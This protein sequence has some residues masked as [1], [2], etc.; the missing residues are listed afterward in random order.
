MNPMEIYQALRPFTAFNEDEEAQLV[1]E[2]L[3]LIDNIRFEWV[4]FYAGCTRFSL[5]KDQF[6]RFTELLG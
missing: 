3:L 4:F 2:R 5:Q 1:E 6:E